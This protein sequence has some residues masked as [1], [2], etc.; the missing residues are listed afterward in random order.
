MRKTSPPG[1]TREQPL[2]AL[3]ERARRDG[4]FDYTRLRIVALPSSRG[5]IACFEL[6]DPDGAPLLC[7]HGLSLSG[8]YFEQFHAYFAANGIRAIAPC[9]LGGICLPDPRK[10]IQDLTGELIELLDVLGIDRFDVIG[11]SW[12]TLAELALLA[13]VPQRIRRAGFLGPMLPLRFLPARDLERMKADVRL[14]LRMAGR[15]PALHRGLMWL[16]CRLPVA[17]LMNQFRDDE[18]SGAEARALAPGSAFAGHLSRSIEECIRT[19]SGFFT[20][21]W[22]MFLDEPGH[23]LGDLASV[24]SRVRCACMWRSETTCICRP[25]R[26]CSPR[27]APAR[28]LANPNRWTPLP[29]RRTPAAGRRSSSGCTRGTAVRSGWRAAPAGW[30]ASS[31]SRR[32]WTTCCRRVGTPMREATA[33]QADR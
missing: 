14:S 2:N 30:P 24:A 15:V 10:T 26:R 9:L 13:R 11:F 32:R 27:H 33:R 20:D 25:M 28:R 5:S 23:A 7:L 4:S 12:G 3:L 6:G 1:E 21:G 22:R 29:A 31:T 16:V 17:A 8:Y 18:L 19:G